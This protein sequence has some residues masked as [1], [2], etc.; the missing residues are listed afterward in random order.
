MSG[1]EYTKNTVISSLIWKFLERAVVQVVQFILSI[2]LARLVTPSDY[3]VVALILIFI[4]SIILP[5]S[6]N[7]PNVL[8]I[9]SIFSRTG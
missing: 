7:I 2:V 8:R 4:P 1:L 5:V 6:S 9:F 3:G